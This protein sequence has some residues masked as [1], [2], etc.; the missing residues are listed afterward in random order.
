MKHEE[1][2][3]ILKMVQ[4]GKISPEEAARLLEALEQPGARPAGPKPTHVRIAI[5]DGERTHS[6]SVGIRLA[7]WVLG[8]GWV[9]LNLGGSDEDQKQLVLEAIENGPVGKV[10]ELSDGDKRLEV[11]LDP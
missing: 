6:F 9:S 5:R 1:R 3:Q 7:R 4:E 10:L 2:L 8:H 11:W